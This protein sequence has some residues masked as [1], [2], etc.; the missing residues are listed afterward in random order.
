MGKGGFSSSFGS[1]DGNAGIFPID[2]SPEPARPKVKPIDA[3]KRT[4]P[5]GV[6]LVK[7]QMDAALE[8]A[9]KND[10]KWNT[11]MERGPIDVERV[12]P[13]I[14]QAPDAA[15]ENH[16]NAREFTVADGDGFGHLEMGRAGRKKLQELMST[17]SRD[18]WSKDLNMRQAVR[19]LSAHKKLVLEFIA[20]NPSLDKDIRGQ[21]E[22]QIE[23]IDSEFQTL[24]RLLPD[25]QVSSVPRAEPRRDATAAPLPPQSAPT[26]TR[27]QQAS[28]M[29]AFFNKLKFWE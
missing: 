2:T 21:L 8:A 7:K 13:T 14:N 18:T 6:N 11:Q 20:K 12:D 28:G 29:K 25:K 16:L 4:P 22:G 23:G 1:E 5:E 15:D 27:D 3:A 10:P 26:H 24:Q 19:E 17:R 9:K